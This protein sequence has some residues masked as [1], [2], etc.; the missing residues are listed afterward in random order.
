VI[1]VMPRARITRWLDQGGWGA[2]GVW[3]LIA[4]VFCSAASQGWA[5]D[6]TEAI[7]RITEINGLWFRHRDPPNTLARGDQVWATDTIR[8]RSTYTPFK[9][10]AILYTSGHRA[11]FTC[12]AEGYCGPFVPADSVR[13]HSLPS[14]AFRAIDNVLRLMGEQPKLWPQGLSRG[15]GSPQEAVLL[16]EGGNVQLEPALRDLPQSEYTV[17][18]FRLTLDSRLPTPQQAEVLWDP[19]AVPIPTKLG[20]LDP[21]LYEMQVLP[22][23]AN[24]NT[25]C[26]ASEIQ[27]AWVL[28]LEDEEYRE[29]ADTF[30][31]ARLVTGTWTGASQKEVRAFLRATLCYLASEIDREPM[32]CQ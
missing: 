1:G 16:S 31:E 4:V 2:F 27:C 15:E 19:E 14:R 28:I 29:A 17:R 32:V 12:P 6:R 22:P 23:R 25:N 18:L 21:G 8:I 30:E 7:A 26:T 11:E 13:R 5:Q 24:G 20:R 9:S 3:L 10:I